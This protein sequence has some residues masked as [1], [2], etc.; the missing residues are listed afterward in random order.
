[1]PRFPDVL[2]HFTPVVGIEPQVVLEEAIE[3]HEDVVV[4]ARINTEVQTVIA[5]AHPE[6]KNAQAKLRRA[7]RTKE[8]VE[9]HIVIPRHLVLL[10]KDVTPV[11]A[12]RL[13]I[14]HL[15][16]GEVVFTNGK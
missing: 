4:A 2:A 13:P 12:Q 9:Q 6:S 14:P 1:M 15:P 16:A 11:P 10:G 7:K 5:Q 3:D 8:D